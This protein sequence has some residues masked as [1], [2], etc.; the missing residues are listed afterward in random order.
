MEFNAYWLVWFEHPD[1]MAP[2]VTITSAGTESVTDTA[3]SFSYT[4]SDVATPSFKYQLDGGVS[5]Y[6][7]ATT[8]SFATGTF[9]VNECAQTEHSF[10]VMSIDTL[11]NEGDMVT[12]KFMVEP[13]DTAIEL[14]NAVTGTSVIQG[15]QAI[16]S[17]AATVLAG[18]TPSSFGY[19]YSVDGGSYT[20][21]KHFPKFGVSGLSEGT[22]TI[23]VRAISTTGCKD[24]TP[25]TMTFSVDTTPP[26]TTATCPM[27]PSKESN[28]VIYG[29]VEDM[30]VIAAGTQY[31]LNDNPYSPLGSPMVPCAGCPA[32]TFAVTLTGLADGTQT[33]YIKS[34]D[35]AGNPGSEFSCTWDKDGG[36][37]PMT[38]IVS[39]APTPMPAGDSATF[40]YTCGDEQCI[41]F[42]SLNMGDY[43]LVH[44]DREMFHDLPEGLHTLKV[45]AQDIVGNVDPTPASYT[46][47]VYGPE[48]YS[49]Y[50]K[51]AGF[52]SVLDTPL[53]YEP[54]PLD[55]VHD[56]HSNMD[57][58]ATDK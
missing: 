32:N 18:A 49:A 53:S 57:A 10:G 51:V 40:V 25:A 11:G 56:V 55:Y 44:G 5:V 58:H 8:T 19:E 37:A 16:F 54:R 13:I 33:L 47:S 28:V 23:M 17:I 39:G 38:A 41:F 2:S 36:A 7:T 3:R 12:Y 42:S 50:M 34:V 29:T 15:S 4:S 52:K 1:T 20:R 31:R 30:N 24:P 45:Y 22:H 43:Q 6:T 46:W 21:G 48:M 26:T 27:G 35:A 14:S 9:P